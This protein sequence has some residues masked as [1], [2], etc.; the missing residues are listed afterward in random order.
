MDVVAA[1]ICG[2]KDK[3]LIAQKA[4]SETSCLKSGLWE[5]PGGKVEPGENFEQ[6]VQREIFE[7]LRM[8]LTKPLF[9]QTLQGPKN[10]NLHF[11]RCRSLSPYCPQEHRAIQWVSRTNLYQWELCELD[12]KL[13][14]Q[15]NFLEW[16]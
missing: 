1:L 6:A 4:S 16:A 5:F 14:S 2:K 3:I 13:L 8:K 9:L 11:F 7:E 12:F 10:L 15:K